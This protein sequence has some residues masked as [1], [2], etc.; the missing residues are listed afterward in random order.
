MPTSDHSMPRRMPMTAELR[1]NTRDTAQL[2]T[3]C[4]FCDALFR[5]SSRANVARG[6]SADR[7]VLETKTVHQRRL[8][9]VAA[10]KD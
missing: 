2:I 6:P 5:Q 8:V 10:V 9:E 1:A 4:A 3:A 7:V